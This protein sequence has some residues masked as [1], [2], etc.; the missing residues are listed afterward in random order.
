MDRRHFLSATS[1]ATLAAGTALAA[2]KPCLKGPRIDLTTGKGNLD[3]MARLEGDLDESKVKYGGASGIV[4]GVRAGEKVRDLFGFEVWSVATTRKQSDGSYRILHRE[5]VYYTDLATEQILTEWV[6]PY[7]NEKVKVVDV[8]NDPWN[9]HVEEFEPLP[10]TYG[11]LNKVDALNRKPLLLN[12][13]EAAGGFIIAQRNVNLYY[14]NALDPD[15]WP[16]ESAGKMVQVSENYTYVVKLEDAQN[17]AMTTIAYVGSWS[18][19]TPWLPWMLMGQ[20]PGHVS[21]QSVSYNGGPLSMMKQT[22]VEHTRKNHPEMMNPP[23]LESL[24]KPNLS[25][26]ENY[27]RTQ[28]PAPGPKS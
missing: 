2:D 22:V 23:P 15:K 14:P 27:A 20:A 25:S 11:G 26:L 5:C 10:P 16:R 17:P 9:S 4:S 28:K 24:Q 7:T 18:R 1:A 8:V 3:L 19:I 6:N 12:W 13:R 21:Y